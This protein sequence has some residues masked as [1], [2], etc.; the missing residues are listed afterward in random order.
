MGRISEFDFDSIVRSVATDAYRVID[1]NTFGF[2]ATVTFRSQSGRSQWEA[3]YDFDAETGDYSYSEN[4]HYPGASQAWA[5]GNTVRDRIKA[6][7][8]DWE[9]AMYTPQIGDIVRVGRGDVAWSV[10][11]VSTVSGIVMLSSTETAIQRSE[12]ASNLEPY[13]G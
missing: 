6:A 10:I 13:D 11:D 3:V 5:F 2:H 9:P 4:P 1:A 8:T 12:L 7:T